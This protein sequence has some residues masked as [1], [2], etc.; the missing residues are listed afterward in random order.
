MS[1]WVNE[2]R[3]HHRFEF[4]DQVWLCTKNLSIEDGIG[5]RKLHT[6]LC[7]PLKTTEQVNE[8]LSKLMKIRGVHNVHHLG[9]LILFVPDKYGWYNE[10]LYPVRLLDGSAEYDVESILESLEIRRGPYFLV[11]WKGY[12]D[13]ENTWEAR[14]DLNK[15]EKA[16]QAYEKL[17]RRYFEREEFITTFLPY[18]FLRNIQEFPKTNGHFSEIDV[19]ENPKMSCFPDFSWNS[20]LGNRLHWYW[21]CHSIDAWHFFNT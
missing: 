19:L 21:Q 14:K 10:E 8:V 15:A 1:K 12:G 11:K 4:N 17:R 16:L 3:I 20:M 2:S 6:K 13:H 18:I 7:G 9:L 5:M